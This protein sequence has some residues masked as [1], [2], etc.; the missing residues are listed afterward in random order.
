LRAITSEKENFL[1]SIAEINCPLIALDIETLDNR[2][3]NLWNEPIISFS[4]SLSDLSTE[5]WDA[6]TATFISEEPAEEN[7]LLEILGN[8]LEANKQAVVAGHNISTSFKN[9]LPYKQG[10]DLPKIQN[11]AAHHNLDFRFVQNLSVYDTMDEAYENYDH[12]THNLQYNGQ[13]QRLLKCTHIENDFGIQRPKWLPKL[14]P[15][16]RETYRQY[17]R[18]NKPYLLKKI[19]LYNASDTIIESIITKI[20]LHH[21]T[22]NC[23]LQTKNISPLNRC[24]HIP[25]NFPIEQNP[26]F[27]RISNADFI[28]I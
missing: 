5:N 9:S 26:S 1:Q 19:A 20:F 18:E 14:G 23:N 28:K 6:P 16:V 25:Q 11:R 15:K 13:K 3:L 12:S 7:R 2:Q 4:I 10:Y 27:A 17:Q 22:S 21:K 24:E 8:I